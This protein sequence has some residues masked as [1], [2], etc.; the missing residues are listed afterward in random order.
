VAKHRL[1]HLLQRAQEAQKR[2]YA[3]YSDFPVGAALET[4]SGTVYTGC[5][6]E[7]SSYS[8][9]LCAERVALFKAVSEGERTFTRIVVSAATEAFC[10]PCGA[11]RQALADFAPDLEVVMLNNKGE[12]RISKL[13]ELLPEAFGPEFLDRENP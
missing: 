6:I 1:N 4:T 2:A 13:A 10:P 12:T 8:L 5:N 11:C 3:P 9:T 7:I